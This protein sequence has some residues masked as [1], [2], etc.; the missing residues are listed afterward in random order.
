MR[1]WLK[2]T[3]KQKISNPKWICKE[4]KFTSTSCLVNYDATI[5]LLAYDCNFVTGNNFLGKISLSFQDLVAIEDKELSKDIF[6]DR[7]LE[8]YGWY[9]WRIK[10][11]AEIKLICLKSDEIKMIITNNEA[12]FVD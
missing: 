8:C 3:F 4:I 1:K 7:P 12:L 6:L 2:T 9:F 5:Y 10:F 11:K